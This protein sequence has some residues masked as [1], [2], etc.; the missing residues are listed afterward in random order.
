MQGIDPAIGG[1][2]SAG[3]FEQDKK[4]KIGQHLIGKEQ[5]AAKASMQLVFKEVPAGTYGIAVFQDLNENRLLETNFFGFPTEPVGFSNGAQINFGPPAFEEAK[6]VVKAQ[7]T[8]RLTI[9]L[10]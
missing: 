10:E 2:V 7:S 4:T 5:S 1:N 6:I 8:L 9:I 3:I